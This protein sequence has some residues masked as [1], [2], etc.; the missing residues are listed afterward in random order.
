MSIATTYDI[1]F[2]LKEMFGDKSRSSYHSVYKMIER[3]PIKD[4]MICMI[5]LLNEM[6]I[7]GV[8]I[9]G[10]TKIDMILERLSLQYCTHLFQKT[11]QYVNPI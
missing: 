11:F 7:L 4:H 2:N 8:E 9:D 5:G 1:F 6:N 3:T 10:E